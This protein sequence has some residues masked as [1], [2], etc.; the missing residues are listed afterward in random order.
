MEQHDIKIHDIAGED[1][2]IETHAM[3]SEVMDR[4][5]QGDLQAAAMLQSILDDACPQGVETSTLQMRMERELEALLG[6][7]SFIQ[8]HTLK[9]QLETLRCDL[10]RDGETPVEVLLIDRVM[11][12]WVELQVY[13]ILSARA[14]RLAESGIPSSYYRMQVS[15]EHRH[16]AAVRT[17]VQIRR[18]MSRSA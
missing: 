14:A 5:Q 6:Q 16:L 4:A 13:G 2:L 7:T 10:C 18:L 1:D 9:G 11:L 15:A 12:T 3:L 8:R 17:L